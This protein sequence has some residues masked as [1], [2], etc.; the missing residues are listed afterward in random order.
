MW[1]NLWGDKTYLD[2]VLT[3]NR[4][5]VDSNSSSEA[6]I[7]ESCPFIGKMMDLSAPPPN[8]LGFNPDSFRQGLPNSEDH[9]IQSL[10]QPSYQLH[11]N[12]ASTRKRK[13]E[14]KGGQFL[15]CHI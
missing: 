6:V 14:R 4:Y 11:S 10:F 8:L 7:D 1:E 2:V 3:Q 9:G 15:L 12:C 13:R 5:Y